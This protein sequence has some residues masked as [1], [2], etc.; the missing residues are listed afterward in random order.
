MNVWLLASVGPGAPSFPN[1]VFPKMLQA[2]TLF[3]AWKPACS[4]SCLSCLGHKDWNR[5]NLVSKACCSYVKNKR[6]VHLFVRGNRSSLQFF[7]VLA[8][9][10]KTYN[11]NRGSTLTAFKWE[12]GQVTFVASA[13]GFCSTE[14]LQHHFWERREEFLAKEHDWV[15]QAAY[16]LQTPLLS[17]RDLILLL[18]LLKYSKVTAEFHK[19]WTLNSQ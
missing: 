6:T 14:T 7:R 15:K 19:E 3:S 5:C 16:A 1:A 18:G 11:V 17:G 2:P 12:G 9:Q 4:S 8:L 13:V 10:V